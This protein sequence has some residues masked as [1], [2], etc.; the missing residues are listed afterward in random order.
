MGESR[1]A[2]ISTREI[3]GKKNECERLIRNEIHHL[4]FNFNGPF[5]LVR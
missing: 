2:G 4:T 1:K 5:A 3:K